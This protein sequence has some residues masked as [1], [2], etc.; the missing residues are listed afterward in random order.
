MKPLLWLGFIFLSSLILN[1]E[2]GFY[3]L[4]EFVTYIAA[5]NLAFLHIYNL[6]HCQC[7]DEECCSQKK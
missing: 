7:Q 6:K 5:S 1:E 2:I 4:P 3:H